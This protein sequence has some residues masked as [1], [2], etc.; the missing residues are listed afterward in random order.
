MTVA[1]LLSMRQPWRVTARA[2]FSKW[3]TTPWTA[4]TG[5]S[6]TSRPDWKRNRSS[7]SSWKV[8]AC[9][10]FLWKSFL[11]SPQSVFPLCSGVIQ[12]CQGMP[13][14][15]MMVTSSI[16]CAELIGGFFF[17]NLQIPVLQKP[18]LF[19]FKSQCLLLQFCSLAV[20]SNIEM[21]ICKYLVCIPASVGHE[22][23]L[24]SKHIFFYHYFCLKTKNHWI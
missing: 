21:G 18:S 3:P 17:S 15:F 24:R 19:P 6:S 23:Y 20:S 12:H 14:R 10:S 16:A 2:A 9:I 4:A 7:A 8:S 5:N 22:L 11:L 13:G 1:F